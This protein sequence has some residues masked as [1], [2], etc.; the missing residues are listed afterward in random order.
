M[1]GEIYPR[2]QAIQRRAENIGWAKNVEERT[3]RRNFVTEP[4][5]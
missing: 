3:S 4:A 2:G 5:R 1:A